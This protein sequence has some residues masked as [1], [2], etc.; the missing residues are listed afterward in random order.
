MS[1]SPLRWT[2]ILDRIDSQLE[3]ALTAAAQR[4]EQAPATLVPSTADAWRAE[5]DRADTRVQ[6]VVDSEARAEIVVREVDDL[7]VAAEDALKEF[8]A[9]LESL[10]QRVAATSSRAI[11]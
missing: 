3:Q 8:R 7:L 10:R 6:I 4:Q 1:D 9:G 2:T 5:L 11:G